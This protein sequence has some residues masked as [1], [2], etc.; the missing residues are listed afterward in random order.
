MRPLALFALLLSAPSLLAAADV[1]FLGP[2][3]QRVP[4]VS[5]IFLTLG[6]TNRG[7]ETVAIAYTIELSGGVVMEPPFNCQ[8][9]TRPLRCATTLIAPGAPFFESITVRAPSVP[10]PFTVRVTADQS[11]ATATIEAVARPDLVVVW[12]SLQPTDPGA[13]LQA[14]GVIANNAPITP[15]RDVRLHITAANGSV[16][17]ASIGREECAVEDGAAVCRI[18]ALPQRTVDFKATVRAA[19]LRSGGELVLTASATSDVEDIDP[20][21]DTAS[22][23]TRIH[24]WIG[25]TSTADAGEGSLRAAIEQANAAGACEESCRIVFEIAEP[26]PA[27]G[28]YTIEPRTP[29]P[30]LTA[31]RAIIDATT[32]PDTNPNG[33]EVLLDGRLLP[34]G[35]GLRIA[36]KC[37]GGVKGLAIGNFLYG[38]VALRQPGCIN[39]PPISISNNYLGVDPGGVNALPNLRG[40][41]IER[42]AASVIDNLIRGNRRSG[43]WAENA[44]AIVRGNRIELNGASGIF[45]G[46][47]VFACAVTENYIAHNLEMGVAVVPGAKIS[48]S[49]PGGGADIRMNSMFANGGLPID[50]GLDGISAPRADDTGVASN[51]PTILSARYDPALDITVITAR[52]DTK[53]LGPYGNTHLIDFYANGAPD[54]DGEQ[55]LTERAVAPNSEFVTTVKGDFTGRWINATSTRVHFIAK[56]AS[57]NSF[58]GGESWTSEFSAAVRV[59]R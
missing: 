56:V 36:T 45:C 10:G 14:A 41:G 21:N 13:T 31:S 26:L 3:P 40:V 34:V 47:D 7:S 58:A 25:V 39:A 9:D 35:D 48:L 59:T 6:I 23:G 57:P 30:E 28:W 32:L 46:P 5:A 33:P 50:I 55:F 54:G 1:V 19:D 44:S 37:E 18:A 52:V 42:G 38:V 15:A 17:A 16:V 49:T 11:V 29:L 24:Q 22:T 53:P 51:P 27:S 4:L 2:P 8:P 43:V 12:R 20:A